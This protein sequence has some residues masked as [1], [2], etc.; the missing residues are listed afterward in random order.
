M[1]GFKDPTRLTRA[2]IVAVSVWMAINS[3]FALVALAEG[4]PNGNAAL[5]AVARLV[6]LICCF[7]TVGMWIYR[8]NANAHALGGDVSITPGWA[9]G[10]FAVP[11]AN[12]VMPYQGVSET[13]QA[14]HEMAG[15]NGDEGL[16]LVRWWWGLWLASGFVGYFA[17]FFTA[18]AAS[19]GVD[20][21]AY[22]L[23]VEA[24]MQIAVS[25]IL[26]RLMRRL[27]AVQTAAQPGQ[28]FA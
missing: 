9:V 10:W 8:T 17:A 22:G 24:V 21:S 1:E 27:A 18:A 6:V 26:I 23:L 25:L 5:I 28:I 19:D 14:S 3:L 4:T 13:W 2:A 16:S 12:L 15:L 20:A 7:V 11:I